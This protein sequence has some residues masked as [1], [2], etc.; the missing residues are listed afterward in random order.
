V[1][2][3]FRNEA[4][5]KLLKGRRFSVEEIAFILGYSEPSTFYRAFRRWTG[6]TPRKFRS[7]A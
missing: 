7:C 3:T 6:M 5:V 1:L 4:T 2:E